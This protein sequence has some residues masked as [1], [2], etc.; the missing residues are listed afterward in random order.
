MNAYLLD[1]P[2]SQV[3]LVFAEDAVKAGNTL[4]AKLNCKCEDFSV[5]GWWEVDPD[6]PINLSRLWPYFTA[7]PGRHNEGRI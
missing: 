3:Y 2:G 6:E 7:S 1:K 5:G 4:A